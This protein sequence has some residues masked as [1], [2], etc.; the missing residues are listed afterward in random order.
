MAS[1]YPVSQ[2]TF[3]DIIPGTTRLSDP[4]VPHPGD[5]NKLHDAVKKIEAKL[6]IGAAV[7]AANQ[8][9]RGIGAGVTDFGQITNAHVDAAAAIAYSKLN[10]ANSIVTGDIVGNAITEKGF[11]GSGSTFSTTSTS[12]VSVTASI[13]TFAPAGTYYLLYMCTGTIANNTTNGLSVVQA[14]VDGTSQ[15]QYSVGQ[16]YTTNAVLPFSIVMLLGPYTGS[17]TFALGLNCGVGTTA[18]VSAFY[19]SLLAIK[20]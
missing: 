17:H 3:V 14:M 16:F 4:T 12:P 8:V 6:G 15:G 1:N 20:K 7:A 18:S 5:H 2:D 11:V 19:Q 9:L 10:L 13:Q